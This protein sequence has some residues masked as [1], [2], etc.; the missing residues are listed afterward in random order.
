L[1]HQKQELRVAVMFVD[2]SGRNEQTL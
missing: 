2:G 1:T